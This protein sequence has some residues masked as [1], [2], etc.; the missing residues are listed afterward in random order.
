MPAKDAP[1]RKVC[2]EEATC[3]MTHVI[4]YEALG[5]PKKIVALGHPKKIQKL[6]DDMWRPCS[7]SEG[8]NGSGIYCLQ[9]PSGAEAQ[10]KLDATGTNV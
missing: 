7:D 3:S 8:A 4:Y 10:Y 6:L 1:F 9:L 5:H 2:N